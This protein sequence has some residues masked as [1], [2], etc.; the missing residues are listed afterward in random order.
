MCRLVYWPGH[1]F[2]SPLRR[3]KVQYRHALVLPHTPEARSNAHKGSV[4]MRTSF[5]LALLSAFV[6]AAPLAGRADTVELKD[7]KLVQGKYV[8][9]TA[10]TSRVETSA[11]VQVIET[12]QVVALTFGGTAA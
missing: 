8:G 5:K 10:T 12:A 7:G 6:L 2:N 4:G 11:G 1:R 9:G 3:T